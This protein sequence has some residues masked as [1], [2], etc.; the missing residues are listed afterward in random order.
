MLSDK[1]NT[2]EN[3]ISSLMT[4]GKQGRD[5]SVPS[6]LILD[7]LQKLPTQYHWALGD[8]Q[9]L[10][11]IYGN[12]PMVR[13]GRGFFLGVLVK[14]SQC[15]G[16]GWP[17][18]SL[19]GMVELIK[20][21]LRQHALVGNKGRNDGDYP[22]CFF[23]GFGV[24]KEEELFLHYSEKQTN[25]AGR[26]HQYK[27][28]TFAVW[29]RVSIASGL[30]SF[31]YAL[32]VA[33]KALADL[34][35]ELANRRDDFL[36][37]IGSKVGYYSYMRS[38]FELL[39]IKASAN[40]E[41]IAFSCQNMAAFAAV[42]VGIRTAYL[43]HGMITRC[44]LLPAF[45]TINVLTT[46][47]AAFM[48][49]RLPKAHVTVYS[50]S[51]QT[52]VPSQMARRILI[53][54]CPVGGDARYMLSV[55]PLVRWAETKKVP[56]R[57]RLHPSENNTFFWSNYEEAGLVTIE[58]GDVDFFQAI[59]KLR[60]RLLVS[61][62]STTLADVLE[63]GVIPVSV[64]ADDDI[65]VAELVYP[66][67]QRCLRWPRDFESIERLLD[68]DDHYASVLSRLRAGL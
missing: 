20:L 4:F 38:W 22:P 32:A 37:H 65:H 6:D 7:K 23:V 19:V 68:D 29:H 53:T 63:C 64:C 43:S 54:S 14:L 58:K 62:V 27:I 42:D 51:R 45:T 17:L 59:A 25:R 41:E 33:R 36:I 1:F 47:E 67:F 10:L 30:R 46:D 60:P 34:P 3:D 48:R 50:T 15:I 26:L 31:F 5:C 9:L 12:K 55:M 40:L 16:M 49:H 44:E 21:L 11:A 24:G 28:E 2:L 57:V 66:I 18:I 39:S 8:G 56:V 35:S 61:W 52:L 13:T